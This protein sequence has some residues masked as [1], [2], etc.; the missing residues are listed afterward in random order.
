VTGTKGGEGG[1]GAFFDQQSGLV[2]ELSRG[3]LEKKDHVYKGPC[4]KRGGCIWRE[5]PRVKGDHIRR[6]QV[7]GKNQGRQSSSTRA[8]GTVGLMAPAFRKGGGER[9]YKALREK[10]GLRKERLMGRCW[11]TAPGGRPEENK[12]QKRDLLI[13]IAATGEEQVYPALPFIRAYIEGKKCRNPALRQNKTH[14][15]IVEI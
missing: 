15:L 7:E 14:E 1:H 6:Q 9:K 3:N 2:S 10:F 4:K 13:L 8:Y 5:K 11:T 12:T